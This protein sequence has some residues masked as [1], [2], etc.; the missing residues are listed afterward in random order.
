MATIVVPNQVGAESIAFPRAAAAAFW[1]YLIGGGMVVVSY[2]INGGP[3]GGNDKGVDLFLASL[4]M[5]VVALVLASICLATT[6]LALRTTGMSLARVPL[7]AWSMLTPPRS[8]SPASGCCSGSL[9]SSTS[10]TVP[11]VRVRGERRHRSLAAV[12]DD[13][14]AGVRV[15]RSGVRASRATSCPFRRT[16]PPQRDCDGD[17]RRV[18]SPLLRCVDLSGPDHNPR[19]YQQFLFVASASRSSC[20]S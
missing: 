4:G 1:T 9:S 10:T 7:F 18:R 16:R 15:R 12:D 8:G 3:F 19:I 14:P 6:V 17:D 13:A 11:A 20:P 2:L 5:V